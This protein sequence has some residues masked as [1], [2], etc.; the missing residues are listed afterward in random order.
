[1]QEMKEIEEK[2]ITKARFYN[3]STSKRN[4]NA[5]SPALLDV[6]IEKELVKKH[7]D[8]VKRLQNNFQYGFGHFN[9]S[10]TKP[11][12]ETSDT[13]GLREIPPA[14]LINAKR[15]PKQKKDYFRLETVKLDYSF[16]TVFDQQHMPAR[17]L[18]S[19]TKKLEPQLSVGNK[20]S[21]AMQHSKLLQ[22]VFDEKKSEQYCSINPYS[23]PGKRRVYPKTRAKAN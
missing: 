4:I 16:I 1:M 15:N 14:K 3:F 13:I 6:Q 8:S 21:S 20:F 10:P 12:W 9:S 22:S 7:K 5:N 23:N 17:T 2:F 11:R 19:K 18:K